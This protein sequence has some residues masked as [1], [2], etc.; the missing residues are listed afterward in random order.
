MYIK[1]LNL[2]KHIFLLL[3]MNKKIK[4]ISTKNKNYIK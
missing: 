3:L 4:M 1:N 2:I